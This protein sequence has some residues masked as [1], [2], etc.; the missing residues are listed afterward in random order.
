[1]KRLGKAGKNNTTRRP[2]PCLVNLKEAEQRTAVLKKAKK[3][4]EKPSFKDI[5]IKKDQHPA[6]RKEW[7][8][9]FTVVEEEKKK[10]ENAGCDISFDRKKR[11]IFKDGII[12]DR[13]H[14][15]DF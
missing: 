6:F 10:P 1:M 5:K 12:I 3:I 8:R 7:Y 11:V 14:L 2:R 15:S 13:W 4:E 9:L